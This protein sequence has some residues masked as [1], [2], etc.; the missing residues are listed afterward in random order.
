MTK[1]AI[2]KESDELNSACLPCEQMMKKVV[3]G[4]KK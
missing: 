2:K 3:K 1:G 4:G